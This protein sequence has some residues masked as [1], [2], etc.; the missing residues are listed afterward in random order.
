MHIFLNTYP[1]M[2][3][4]FVDL[5]DIIYEFY[6]PLIS[7]ASFGWLVSAFFSLISTWLSIV[8][9]KNILDLF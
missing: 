2:I 1:T 9:F 4:S 6:L 8:G 3:L 5:K 7:I